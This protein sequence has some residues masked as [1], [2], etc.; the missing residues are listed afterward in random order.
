MRVI[1]DMLTMD[2]DEIDFEEDEAGEFKDFFDKYPAGVIIAVSTA[3]ADENSVPFEDENAR[4]EQYHFQ[5]LPCPCNYEDFYRIM[6]NLSNVVKSEQP[7]KPKI[8]TNVAGSVKQAILGHK[9]LH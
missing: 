8:I 5:G 3:E 2:A 6:F 4:A 9:K 1:T 7:D